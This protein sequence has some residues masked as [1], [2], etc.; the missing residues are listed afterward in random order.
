MVSNEILFYL[1]VL[2]VESVVL[3]YKVNSLNA[4]VTIDWFPYDGN[5][6]V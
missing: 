2:R 6:G 5:F 3:E 4:K 1:S